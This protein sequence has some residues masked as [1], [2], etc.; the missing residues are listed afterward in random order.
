M[1]K[2]FLVSMILCVSLSIAWQDKA[3][4]PDAET[5]T[6]L[7]MVQGFKSTEGQLMVAVYNT[8]KEFMNKDP[9]KGSITPLSASQE[10]IRFDNLPYGDYAVVVLHDMN[11]D[12]ILDKNEFG[13]PT[14]GYGFSNNVMGKFGPPTW[15][16]ASFVFAG[17]DEVKIIELE[18]GIPKKSTLLSNQ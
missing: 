5:G 12:G 16:Q 4:A 13:I 6:L 7:V 17:R 2:L 9:F 14:E 11:K 8:E 1:K 18:Y 15:M 10:L 3:P